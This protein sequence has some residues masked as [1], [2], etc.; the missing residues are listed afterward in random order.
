VLQ[1][2]IQVICFSFGIARSLFCGMSYYV[3]GTAIGQDGCNQPIVIVGGP[4]AVGE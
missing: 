4:A 3:T 2:I 1:C